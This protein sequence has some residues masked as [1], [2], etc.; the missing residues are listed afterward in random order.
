MKQN[1]S[2]YRQRFHQFVCEVGLRSKSG[3]Y[4]TLV[5]VHSDPTRDNALIW[6]IQNNNAAVP[7]DF[8]KEIERLEACLG[9]VVFDISFGDTVCQSQ[10]VFRPK[11]EEWV[12]H[13]NISH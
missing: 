8:D 13:E 11:Q 2:D 4:P 7:P 3:E 5:S 10:F 6:T 12:A 1:I 9:G